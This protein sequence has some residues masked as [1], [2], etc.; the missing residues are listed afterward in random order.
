MHRRGGVTAP[1]RDLRGRIRGG[2]KKGLR[3]TGGAQPAQS[4][5][6][7]QTKTE[8]NDL[9]LAPTLGLA[10]TTQPVALLLLSPLWAFC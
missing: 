2:K 8:S 6:R 1:A 3:R 4:A 5:S 9:E 10:N 7:D